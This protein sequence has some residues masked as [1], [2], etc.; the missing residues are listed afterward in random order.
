MS[1]VWGLDCKDTRVVL[2]KSISAFGSS[3]ESDMNRLLSAIWLSEL[4]KFVLCDVV[5]LLLCVSFGPKVESCAV[6]LTEALLSR[7]S[8]TVVVV[9]D[10]CWSS[11]FCA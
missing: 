2:G 1:F 11:V 8:L 6:G 5:V 3:F 9:F 7:N 4:R 10:D